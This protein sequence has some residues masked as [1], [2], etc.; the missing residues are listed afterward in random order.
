MAKLLTIS[1]GEQKKDVVI[2][3]ISV[4]PQ[5]LRVVVNDGV[6]KND[7][8]LGVQEILHRLTQETNPPTDS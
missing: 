1:V 2:T 5:D 6:T 3:T 7:S 4:Q 8:I